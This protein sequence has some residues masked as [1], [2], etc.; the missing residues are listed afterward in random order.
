[1]EMNWANVHI[2]EQRQGYCSSAQFYIH[3][4][5]IPI[6][7]ETGKMNTSLHA[8][9][10]LIIHFNILVCPTFNISL[11]HPRLTVLIS[12]FSFSFI[13]IFCKFILLWHPT[14]TIK[15]PFLCTASFNIRNM[16]KKYGQISFT[17]RLHIFKKTNT[18]STRYIYIIYYL[19]FCELATT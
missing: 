6:L 9:V 16:N 10:H 1:M 5:L 7:M 17:L 12:A 2:S 11:E 15:F 4:G 3:R 18:N 8:F 14:R 13:L 19:K